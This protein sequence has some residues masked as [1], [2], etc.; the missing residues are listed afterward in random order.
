MG[1]RNCPIKCHMGISDIERKTPSRICCP[2]QRPTCVVDCSA[3][4][5]IMTPPNRNGA[6]PNLSLK[7]GQSGSGVKMEAEIR[8]IIELNG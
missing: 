6:Q 8:Q 5:P 7:A 3:T 4:E 1:E 2:A